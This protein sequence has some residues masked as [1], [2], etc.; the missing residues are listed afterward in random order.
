MDTAWNSLIEYES[1][2][3]VERAYQKRHGRTLNANAVQEITSSFIQAREYYL[4]AER[5]AITVRPLLQYY[6]VLALTRGL[7][8]ILL[9]DNSASALKPSH[10]LDAKHWQGILSNGLSATGS[11]EVVIHE[12]M[13]LDL[14][15]ATNNTS[16]LRCNSSWV[17]GYFSFA[18]PTT[19]QSFTLED[20]VRSNLD[21]SHEYST[22][23]GTDF[24]SLQY[25]SSKLKEESKY[26][27]T[28]PKIVEK[29]YVEKVF[30]REQCQELE[31][32]HNGNKTIITLN[33]TITPYF[34]QRSDGFFG[35]GDVYIVPLIK[36]G[37]YLNTPSLYFATSYI[38]GMLAR[39]FPATWISLGRVAKGDAIFPLINRLMELIQHKYPQVVLDFLKTP[40]NFQATK[41]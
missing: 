37:I 19:E 14:L 7:I 25:E 35:I 38:L 21:V 39:Y 5:A 36:D 1:R 6:G 41:E 31:I 10:G 12:G 11:L 22:W 34:S 30:P 26:E 32:I 24:V 4:N 29:E 28:I 40:Y 3:L 23:K 18:L 13:F 15:K 2:D 20:V 17:N 8:L 16:Y 33:S 27:L 9:R